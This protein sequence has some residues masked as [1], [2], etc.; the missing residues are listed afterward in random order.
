M[1]HTGAMKEQE[2]TEAAW[3]ATWGGIWGGAKWGA[4]TALLSGIGWYASPVYRGLTL[5]F[6][7]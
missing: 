4:A 5:Q 3:A 7:V 1:R 6:K 2:A